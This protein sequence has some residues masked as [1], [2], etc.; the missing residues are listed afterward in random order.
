MSDLEDMVTVLATEGLHGSAEIFL[1]F[2][3]STNIDNLAEPFNTH[4]SPLLWTANCLFEQHEYYRASEY[5]VRVGDYMSFSSF[6]P[7]S[8]S[9]VL[10]RIGQVNWLFFFVLFRF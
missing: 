9:R 2:L 1:D 5:Y 3:R 7:Q 10:M 8:I 6:S 4:F